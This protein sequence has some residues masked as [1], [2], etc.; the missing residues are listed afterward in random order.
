MGLERAIE[1][2]SRQEDVLVFDVFNEETAFALGSALRQR[3][4]AER[5][6]IAIDVRLWDR[7]LFYCALPGSTGANPDWI[8]RKALTVQRFAR[9]TYRLLLENGGIE[10]GML[11]HPRWGLDPRDYALAGGG[12]PISVTGAKS[13]GAMTVSGLTERVDHML[14]VDTIASFL[15]ISG[16]EVALPQDA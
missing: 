8:R 7:P 1:A 2:V 10:G 14:V 3:G 16:A 12:F 4:L 6:P 9:S 15:G 5:L 11:L 13:I